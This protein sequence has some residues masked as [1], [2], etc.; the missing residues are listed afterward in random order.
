LILSRGSLLVLAALYVF[1][2]YP[3]TPARLLRILGAFFALPAFVAWLVRRA[4]AS[5]LALD[6][7]AL[8]VERRTRRIEI[9]LA[10]IE[11]VR[12][13]AVPLPAGG[14]WLWLRS[15]RR[16]GLGV[17][18]SDPA[19]WAE[20]LAKAGV[21]EGALRA[22]SHPNAIYAR[23]RGL[24][25]SRWDHPLLKYLVFSLVPTL[26]LFRLHQ[27]IAYG[28]ALGEYYQYGLRAYLLGFAVHWTLFAS[29]LLVYGAV[30][31]AAVEAI[32]L[33]AAWIVP[34]HAVTVRRAAEVTQRI[35][36]YAGI[37]TL[38]VLRFLFS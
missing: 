25:R 34:A 29:Y 18:A 31:R 1:P 20:D 8:V 15:G 36:F 13:W 14:C 35:V 37:P 21:A 12:P 16:F 11:S 5:T 22:A 38:L 7:E 26:P 10:S 9:P 17:E 24:A 28:A 3:L 19:R 23:A 27:F 2:W 6:G 30:L 4:C 32:S 33:G